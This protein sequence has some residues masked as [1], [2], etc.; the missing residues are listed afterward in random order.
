MA[1]QEENPFKV[2]LQDRYRNRVAFDVT[3]DLNE[4]RNTNYNSL[5]PVHMPGAIQIYKNTSSRS[6][7][8]SNARFLSRTPQEAE[9][10]IKKLWTLRG[11][12]MPRFG[13]GSSTLNEFSRFA[14]VFREKDPDSHSWYRD[15][16]ELDQSFSVGGEVVGAPPR[17]IFL[18]AY[19]SDAL[20]GVPQHIYRVPTVLANLSIPYP[21]DVD[22]VN[23]RAGVPVPIIMT[24]DLTL[25]ETHSP[26]QYEQFSLYAYK[27]GILPGF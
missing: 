26:S 6:F 23:T 8:I 5:E 4:T 25:T 24:V 3:P 17:I 19:S 14:R 27:N 22:Y 11:W 15:N 10:T 12:G 20:A 9:R 16:P 13:Q 2:R 7:N 21:G 1:T 18:S